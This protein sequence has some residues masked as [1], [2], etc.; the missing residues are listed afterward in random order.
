VTYLLPE[1]KRLLGESIRP[2]RQIDI[3]PSLEL[4]VQE[5]VPDPSIPLEEHRPQKM[6]FWDVLREGGFAF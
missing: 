5:F 4:S 6:V 3:I 2:D 1:T